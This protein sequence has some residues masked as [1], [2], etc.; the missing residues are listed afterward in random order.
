MKKN[1]LR[2]FL[3]FFLAFNFSSLYANLVTSQKFNYT[4]DLPEGFEITDME[5]DE[6]SVIFKSRYLEAYALS[7]IWENSRFSSAKEALFETLSK[8]KSESE[9]SECIWR[10]QKCAIASFSSDCL[11]DENA[12]G[13]GISVPLPQ[14]KGFLVLLA[15]SPSK[16]EDD[17]QQV[18]ISILDSAM[19][20]KGSFKE[21]GII[22][23]AF[24]PRNSPKKINLAINGKSFETQIDKID[25]E[26]SQ[27]IIDREW[28]VFIFYVK[29]NL[30]EMLDAWT[31]FYRILAKD[32][33]ERLKRASFDI[34]SN[35]L[36]EAE[37]KDSSNPDAAL[38][39]ILLFWAQ[40]FNYGRK[41]AVFD[42][43]DI[44]S[45]PAILE[46]GASDCDGRSL[47]LMCILK[48]CGLDACMFVSAEYSHALLGVFFPDKQGQTISVQE[49]N[50]KKDYL[51]GETTAKN[52]TLGMIP[53]DMQDRSK[54]ISVE[55]P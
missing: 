48:N 41:S 20:D 19:I 52:V 54:W 11:L 45:I 35:L 16:F 30:P 5:E 26:A 42:K 31:R 1:S 27:F 44:E 51:V 39:Q 50:G 43:A 47:L 55:L 21:P 38:A 18:L 53:A 17:L 9:F 37:K 46:G 25:S 32:S 12:R 3:F 7:K 2:I 40:N 13:W 28:A 49:E 23:S 8:L 24:F 29:N 34:Y 15:Y 33:V 14:K 36:S 10:R 6:T 22:T 4:L